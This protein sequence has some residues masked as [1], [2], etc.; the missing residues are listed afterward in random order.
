[1]LSAETA[2]RMKIDEVKFAEAGMAGHAFSEALIVGCWI[3]NDFVEHE[4]AWKG[5]KDVVH[6]SFVV[7]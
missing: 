1:M 6:C 2:V 5:A 3:W 7:K 4:T